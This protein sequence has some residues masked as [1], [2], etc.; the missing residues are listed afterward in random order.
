MYEDTC[1][2][3]L[4]ASVHE[5]LQY[6]AVTR[7]SDT[8]RVTRDVSY[9]ICVQYHLWIDLNRSQ[10]ACLHTRYHRSGPSS[11]FILS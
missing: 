3:T 7:S 11:I 1:N 2:V 10:L 5:T 6:N 4:K 9:T 8:M